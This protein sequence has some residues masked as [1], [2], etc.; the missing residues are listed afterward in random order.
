MTAPTTERRQDHDG[1]PHR[2]RIGDNLWYIHP[3]TEERFLSVTSVLDFSEKEGLSKYWRPG[4]A[5]KAAFA[6][7]PRLVA[8]TRKKPCGRAYA[9][10]T[11][12]F[13]QR[14][15]DCPCQECRDCLT[16]YL[17]Y[18]HFA[19]SKRAT[20]RGSEFHD[21]V[22]SW[23]LYGG[24]EVD[25]DP[26]VAPYAEAFLQ[27]A[28]DYGLTPES[29]DMAEATVLHRDHMWGGTLDGRVRIA[30]TRSKKARDLCSR[31][32][33]PEVLLSLDTKTHEGDDAAFYADNA[34]QLAAYRRGQVVLFDDGREEPLQPDDG[35]VVV[36]VRP[37]G[38]G[39]RPV[40]TD[41]D[42]YEGFLGLLTFA[43]WSIAK[44]AAS[45]QVKTFPRLEIPG[46]PVTPTR[47]AAPRKAAVPKKA[48]TATAPSDKPA[49][50][51]KT[52]PAKAAAPRQTR[53]SAIRGHL[54]AGVAAARQAP[55]PDS[56]HGDEIPF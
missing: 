45:T 4:L 42:A 50:A 22:E 51:R 6:E 16:R 37:N 25:V 52:T 13:R 14:C 53:P 3:V 7:L 35:A 55:H 19:E 38:Y 29:W 56:P 9:K 41:D 43:R 2:H 46:E 17:T 26:E 47:K 44:G 39:V 21:F 18:R 33:Q 8:A 31:F 34:L 30:A 12:D 20:D 32:G 11:H 54:L 49:P 48:L 28:E 40:V 10:C 36:Q 23:V 24:R 27:F 5:A 1:P 15:T